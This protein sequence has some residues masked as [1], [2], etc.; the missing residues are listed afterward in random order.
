MKLTCNK[1]QLI[2]IINTVQKAI[3]AKAVMPIL[4]CIKIDSSGDGNVTVTANNLDLCIEYNTK[5]NVSEGGSIAL[6]SKMFGEIVRSMPD[7]DVTV[8]VNETNNVTKIKSGVS[9][10]NIQGVVAG[11]FPNPP[12]LEEKFKF[13]IPSENL[14]NYNPICS[15]CFPCIFAFFL[16]II[17]K[18][19]YDVL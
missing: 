4:E 8:S 18:L 15:G 11:E 16:A 2:D 3:A 13:S 1:E 14:K 6:A 9:E 12:V 5:C 17:H 7:G 10:F 19:Q